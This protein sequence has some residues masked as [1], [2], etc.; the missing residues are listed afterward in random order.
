[1]RPSRS[2]AGFAWPVALASL[3]LAACGTTRAYSGAAQSPAT[4]A[5]IRP[6]GAFDETARVIRV[7]ETGLGVF[8]SSIE[9]LPGKHVVTMSIAVPTG[10]SATSTAQGDVEIVAE[11]GAIYETHGT[12]TGF[13]PMQHWFW[14]VDAA[15]RKLA[16]GRR[17]AE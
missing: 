2:L 3:C 4:I 10:S 11:A 15:T 13:F 12:T 1:M 6:A 14:I 16:G 17:P 8:D 5:L 7:D 9:V